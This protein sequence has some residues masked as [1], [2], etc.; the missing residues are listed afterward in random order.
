LARALER[1]YP[2]RERSLGRSGEAKVRARIEPDGTV[3]IA[4]L[5]FETSA[6]FGEACR[7]T[8]LAS[9]WTAPLDAR[10]KPAATWITYLCKFRVGT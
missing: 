8:L 4:K 9:R 7:A 10:G 3:R 1:N 6:G 2:A 5:L